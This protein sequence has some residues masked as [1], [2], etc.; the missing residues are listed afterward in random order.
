MSTFE[1]GQEAIERLWRGASESSLESSLLQLRRDPAARSP[2]L[3]DDDSDHDVE[4]VDAHA[5]H[6]QVSSQAITWLL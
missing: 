6:I 5:T 2:E 3:L 4:L 1:R